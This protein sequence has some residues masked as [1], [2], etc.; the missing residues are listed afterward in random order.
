MC[1]P[2]FLHHPLSL[3]LSALLLQVST[4]LSFVR[5]WLHAYAALA[6]SREYQTRPPSTLGILP[7]K[8]SQQK[9][10]KKTTESIIKWPVRLV[11]NRSRSISSSKHGWMRSTPISTNTNNRSR[12]GTSREKSQACNNRRRFHQGVL[13]Y[14]SSTW[15]WSSSCRGIN[16]QQ[17]GLHKTST[18]AKE[19]CSY[20]EL[21]YFL[22]HTSQ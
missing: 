2:P 13:Y 11:G 9:R 3:F 7:A 14:F 1:F 6:L 4:E 15:R 22:P 17:F 20:Y 5:L 21:A 8:G 19:S 16:R 10:K 18:L 12:I